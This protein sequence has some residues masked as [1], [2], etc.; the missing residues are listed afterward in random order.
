MMP[1]SKSEIVAMQNVLKGDRAAYKAL[2]AAHFGRLAG[3]CAAYAGDI[4][5]AKEAI[6]EAGGKAPARAATFDGDRSFLA[7]LADDAVDFCRRKIGRPLPMPESMT[8]HVPDHHRVMRDMVALVLGDLDAGERAF[9]EQHIGQ[10]S[11]CQAELDYV[12]Q[13]AGRATASSALKLDQVWSLISA[14][15]DKAVAARADASR[16]DDA[17]PGRK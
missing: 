11:A 16:G 7:W 14:E 5:T 9:R 3:L 15:M 12:R 6:V 2:L 10:C 4:Q 1:A 8:M 13:A 17:Q